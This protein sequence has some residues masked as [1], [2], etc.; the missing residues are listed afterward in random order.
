MEEEKEKEE[1]TDGTVEKKEDEEKKDEWMEN[2]MKDAH[3]LYLTGRE[4]VKYEWYEGEWLLKKAADMGDM[5]AM[6]YLGYLYLTGHY[7]IDEQQDKALDLFVKASNEGGKE[8]MR[9]AGET[10]IEC[11][12]LTKDVL[13]F[14]EQLLVKAAQLGDEKALDI[15]ISAF[16]DGLN[17]D[18]DKV[19]EYTLMKAEKG[20]A[21][22]MK[23]MAERCEKGDRVPKDERKAFLWYKKAFDNGENSVWEKL[24]LC[25]GEGRGTNVNPKEEFDVYKK[26]FERNAN[27]VYAASMLMECLV[28]GYGTRRNKE[29]ALEVFRKANGDSFYY[30]KA[31][32]YLEKEEEEK[33]GFFMFLSGYKAD[34]ENVICM[35]ALIEC[36]E[37]GIGTERDVRKADRIRKAYKNTISVLKRYREYIDEEY[38]SKWGVSLDEGEG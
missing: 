32:G 5:D 2:L 34:E 21:S 31:F 4:T 6:I 25:Y 30:R 17:R 22:A 13:F 18:P 12:W 16:R 19:A 23:E 10:I 33:K 26:A 37:K 15:L 27:D 24:S 20:N 3:F 11:F 8:G 1:E 7:D 9:R 38:L 14:G 29:E 35:K 36:Y 28:D